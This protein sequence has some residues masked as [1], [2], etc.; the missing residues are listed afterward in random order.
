M[1]G[2]GAAASGRNGETTS[3]DRDLSPGQTPRMEL[4]GTCEIRM[5]PEVRVRGEGPKYGARH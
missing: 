5:F 2:A 4:S 1:L 3:F